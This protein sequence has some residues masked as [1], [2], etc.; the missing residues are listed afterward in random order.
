MQICHNTRKT[1]PWVKAKAAIGRCLPYTRTG[2]QSNPID[3]VGN[4]LVENIDIEQVRMLMRGIK[5]YCGPQNY[6]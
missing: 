1:I 6:Y 2:D 4:P 3:M 5:R